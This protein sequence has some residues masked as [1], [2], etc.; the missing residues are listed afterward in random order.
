MDFSVS[1]RAAELVEAVRA[2][3]RDEIAPVEHELEQR[4]AA[5]SSTSALPGSGA[6][7]LN[8]GGARNDQPVASAIAP[9]PTWRRR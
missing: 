6:L 9:T 3:I 2:F 1:P 4:R 5:C 7:Q 8:T